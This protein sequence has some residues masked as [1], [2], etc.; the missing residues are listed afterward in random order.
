MFSS[1]SHDS[2]LQKEKRSITAIGFFFTSCC[3]DGNPTC[4]API[5]HK[6][7]YLTFIVKQLKKSDNGT[8]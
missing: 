4:S 3:G 8:L 5:H 1:W 6:G 2:F 7:L